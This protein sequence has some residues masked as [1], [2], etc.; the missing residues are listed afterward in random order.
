MRT[1]KAKVRDAF[2]EYNG[3]AELSFEKLLDDSYETVTT[4][5]V[6]DR[7]VVGMVGMGAGAA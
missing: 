6:P 4:D 3:E 5:E 1:P 7:A 2:R